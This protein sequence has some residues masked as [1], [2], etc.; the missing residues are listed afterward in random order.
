MNKLAVNIYKIFI[1]IKVINLIIFIFLNTFIVTEYTE[2]VYFIKN[3]I[4]IAIFIFI[5]NKY[6]Y[7]TEMIGS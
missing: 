6:N 7:K 5:I 4:I 2:D 3:K 1:G